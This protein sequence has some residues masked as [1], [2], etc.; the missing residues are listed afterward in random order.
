MIFTAVP[1]DIAI[2]CAW[3]APISPTTGRCTG[4]PVVAV[5]TSACATAY[6][7]MPELSKEGSRIGA[8]TSSA[9]ASPRVSISG[10]GKSG[11]G[12]S[13]ARTRARWS[14]TEVGPTEVGPSGIRAA[15]RRVVGEQG[16]GLQPLR[17]RRLELDLAD[18]LDALA[19][20]PV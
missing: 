17:G 7:S 16:T 3:P 5:T 13:A 10:W 18:D 15:V 4:L 11:S 8:A 12:S 19:E 6:P 14:S 1:G 20:G 9:A 2:S